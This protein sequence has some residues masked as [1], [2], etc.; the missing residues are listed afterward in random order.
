MEV[1]EEQLKQVFS[2]YGEVKE[3]VVI[4]DRAGLSMGFGYV[5]FESEKAMRRVEQRD[6]IVVG[7]RTVMT[8]QAVVRIPTPVQQGGDGY[9]G[10]DGVLIHQQNH[11]PVSYSVY[12]PV[13][14]V[15]VYPL[16]HPVH[17]YQLPI[18]P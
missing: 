7:G 5:K 8:A 2:V 12:Y 6:E 9:A 11:P 16:H 1:D 14:I 3:V 18:W 4:L 17:H 10:G 15:P 13:Q